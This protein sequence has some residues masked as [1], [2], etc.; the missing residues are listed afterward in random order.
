MKRTILALAIADPAVALV[1]GCSSAESRLDELQPN[2]VDTAL[3]R[4][5]LEMNCPEATGTVVSR[6]E[7]DQPLPPS[8]STSPVSIRVGIVHTR[9]EYAI[10]IE[11]CGKRT[12]MTVVCVEDQGSCVASPGD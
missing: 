2:A 9:A 4:A 5:R 11:G 7:V 12:T 10:A 8:S 6:K 3:Q 1:A